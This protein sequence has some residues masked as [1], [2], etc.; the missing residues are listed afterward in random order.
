MAHLAWSIE[1][2]G[3][4]PECNGETLVVDAFNEMKII[5]TDNSP[6][7]RRYYEESGD[8]VVE[9][10]EEISGHYCP[11]CQKL[12]SLYFNS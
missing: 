3:R 6:F 9:I 11:K 8:G 1:N 5:V 7:Q 4:C 2:N 12:T 10:A